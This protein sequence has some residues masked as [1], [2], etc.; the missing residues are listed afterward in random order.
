VE[1]YI[2]VRS[3]DS[4]VVSATDIQ[5]GKEV[6]VEKKCEVKEKIEEKEVSAILR[7]S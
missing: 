4:T 5:S 2:I 1:R 6:K 7:R 3:D